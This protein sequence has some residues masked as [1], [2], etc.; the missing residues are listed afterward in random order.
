MNLIKGII[1]L[2]FVVFFN[3]GFCFAQENKEQVYELEPIVITP[4][5]TETF[6]NLYSHNVNIIKITPRQN[7][8]KD[9]PEVLKNLSVLDVQ[10]RGPF[11][12]QSDIQM[13]GGNFEQTDILLDGIN[14]NDPQTGHFN[15]DI[16]VML[17]DI[18][19]III[20]SGPA[21]AVL[22]SSRPGGAVHIITRPPEPGVFTIKS[23]FGSHE[24]KS[25]YLSSSYKFGE[26]M[27]RNSAFLDSCAGYRHNTDFENFGFSQSGQA[28]TG[29]GMLD[30]S[31]R[32]LSK[33]FGANG[34]YSEFYP[35]Q[36]EQ[37][38][39][40]FSYLGL[41]AEVGDLYINPKIYIRRHKDRF[42]L[43]EANPG[44]F[45][46]FHTNYTTGAKVDILGDAAFGAYFTGLDAKEESIDSTN[47]GKHNRVHQ[48]LYCRIK[49]D[50]DKYIFV[51]G[52]SFHFFEDYKNVILPDL[53][54]GAWL[55]DTL[56]LRS[57][58]SCSVR[59]P[60]FTELYYDSPA[61]KGNQA[62]LCEK[63]DNYEI[64]L[65]SEHDAF[66]W[67]ITGFVREEKNIID[68]V[69]ASPSSIYNAM[70]CQDIKTKG[71]Q[72][73]LRIFSKVPGD[74]LVQF[75]QLNFG[76]TYL[77]RDKAGNNL[78]SKYVFD[79]L[80]HKFTLGTEYALFSQMF[81]KL[82]LMY[83]ER[84]NNPGD[85]VLDSALS[86]SCKFYT[87]FLKIDNIFNHAYSEK[88]GIPLPGRWL[89]A[90]VQINW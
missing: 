20:T 3:P 78:I 26:F 7:N 90:G 25:N 12:I 62:L 1:P 27:F 50:L 83:L 31:L 53:G 76:Y 68:W 52:L 82:N 59:A 16:P 87:V 34:F 11:T 66:N 28:Q 65:D 23:R 42:M 79:Y 88:A 44:F 81:L 38:Q 29:W 19:S 45:E 48:N 30:F 17:E 36:A 70:N 21:P 54:T 69:R 63:S 71:A 43:D 73:D 10:T 6:S 49:P 5:L 33:D 37:T 39:T 58:Y 9:L 35:N 55:T 4:N 72:V 75:K 67:S 22:G 60:T 86:K 57:S 61:N 64:G 51:T 74:G 8:G 85:F 41:K 89:S 2:V 77:E 84:V 46:N 32:H 80:Q 13:R 18:D 47:L 40:T 14:V 24:F 56:K 15:M